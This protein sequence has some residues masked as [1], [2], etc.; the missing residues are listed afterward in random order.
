MKEKGEKKTLFRADKKVKILLAVIAALLFLS[1][2]FLI[3]LVILNLPSVDSTTG[4]TDTAEQEEL[5]DESMEE[6]TE[7]TTSDHLLAENTDVSEYTDIVLKD[8]EGL[9]VWVFD[10]YSEDSWVEEE[11]RDSFYPGIITYYPIDF[12]EDNMETQ[13]PVMF[14]EVVNSQNAVTDEQKDLFEKAVEDIQEKNLEADYLDIGKLEVFNHSYGSA[15]FI[16][17]KEIENVE[18]PNT[19]EVFS[20]LTVGGYQ[21]SPWANPSTDEQ[22]EVN[23]TIFVFAIKGDNIISL[24]SFDELDSLEME[25]EDYLSCFIEEEDEVYEGYF[26]T[27]CLAEVL[28]SGKYDEQAKELAEILVER[29]ESVE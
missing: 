9:G 7:D 11:D 10:P 27:N 2:T 29:F 28:S 26:D 21:D 13:E 17:A 5:T 20:V 15:A 8:Y 18:Y 25:R 14:M 6:Q 24:E 12:Y 3:T 19:D 4:G 1:L 16:V 23:M 22:F